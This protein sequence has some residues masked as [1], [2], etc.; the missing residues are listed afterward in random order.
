MSDGLEKPGA[1]ERSRS[2]LLL[3]QA[4]GFVCLARKNQQ[5]LLYSTGDSAQYLVIT[6]KGNESESTYVCVCVCVSLNRFA[7]HLNLTV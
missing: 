7:V 2:E 4:L 1:G 3:C 5:A 6:Y